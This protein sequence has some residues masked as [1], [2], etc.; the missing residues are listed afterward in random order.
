[1]DNIFEKAQGAATKLIVKSAVNPA[2]W[3]SAII[4]P[5]CFSAAFFLKDCRTILV[6]AGMLPI[7]LVIFAY[8]FFMLFDRDRLHSEEFQLRKLGLI[9]GKDTGEIKGGEFL[10]SVI[11]PKA[12]AEKKDSR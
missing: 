5:V 6:I 7:I 9:R 11:N 2:L 8:I 3:F 12:L 4:T 10:P 1:M